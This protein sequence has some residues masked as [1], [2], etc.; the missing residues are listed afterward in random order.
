LTLPVPNDPTLDGL[1][2]FNQALV[3]DLGVNPAGVTVSN[4]G[5]GVISR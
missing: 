5:R 1:E 4:G 2:F 3:V